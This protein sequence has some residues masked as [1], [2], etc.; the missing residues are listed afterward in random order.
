MPQ[1]K[2][3]SLEMY[4]GGEKVAKEMRELQNLT[5]IITESMNEMATGVEQVNNA[6]QEV[7]TISIKNK[8]SIE[9]LSE[10]VG[11]FKI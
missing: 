2:D 10:V 8:E 9:V 5:R 7:N 4:K 3:G 11:K 1:S 6:V